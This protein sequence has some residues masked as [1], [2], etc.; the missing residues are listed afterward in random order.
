M[1]K[2]YIL[3]IQNCNSFGDSFRDEKGTCLVGF[4]LPD[5]IKDGNGTLSCIIDYNGVLETA[6]K[7]IPIL[8]NSIEVKCYPEGG[9]LIE[10][11]QSGLY[12]E[13]FTKNGDPADLLGEIIDK[14]NN[15]I[16]SINTIVF[17]TF[18]SLI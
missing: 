3:P 7:T 18:D 10:E 11:I 8:I 14:N 1:E 15:T 2:K 9:Y 12:I 6:S 13:C 5:K 16:C 17:L 4:S